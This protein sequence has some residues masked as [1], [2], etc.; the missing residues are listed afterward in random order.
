MRQQQS[1]NQIEDL[2][3]RFYAKVQLASS[4]RRTDANIIAEDVLVP[5]FKEL[6]GYHNLHNV[7]HVEK[8][9][10]AID[11]ADDISRVAIQITA[12]NTAE[13]VTDTLEKFVKYHLYEKY[14][15]L[16]IYILKNKTKSKKNYED[17]TEN[18]FN[19]DPISNIL[20]YKDL[21]QEAFKFDLEKIEN[22]RRILDTHFGDDADS[23]DT[24]VDLVSTVTQAQ[25]REPSIDGI[26]HPIS[27]EIVGVIEDKIENG[28]SVLITGDAGSGKTGVAY[29][30]CSP[31]RKSIEKV[32]Y[33]DARRYSNVTDFLSLDRE[34]GLN[35]SLINAIERLG[36]L[37][38][39]RLIIDQ[40]DSVSAD[41][42]G[43]V[44]ANL[45]QKCLRLHGVKVVVLSRRSEASEI[46]LT[47]I[48]I[49]AG[50]QE[51]ICEDLP[52]PVIVD[53]FKSIGLSEWSP[54]IL[55]LS[56]NLLNLSLVSQIKLTNPDFDFN[57]ILDENELW[58][59][60][61]N[62]IR[63]S[64]TSQANQGVAFGDYVIAEAMRIARE[65]MKSNDRTIILTSPSTVTQRRLE[66]WRIIIHN[67]GYSY[68]F[69]H[70]K[71]HDFLFAHDATKRLLTPNAVLTEIGAH[72]AHN[73]LPWIE[74]LYHQSNK[75]RWISFLEHIFDV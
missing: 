24:L 21:V 60:Y 16:I 59:K 37:F 8:N 41:R 5:L 39:C 43:G 57:L 71:L 40:L 53:I 26:D 6:Y 29:A 56:K 27:R 3:A 23:I 63:A 42:A 28:N 11:L 66:S 68:R 17:I 67:E 9:K 10:Y 62:A 55:F 15:H 13:K 2:M 52:D 75:K 33:F 22:V 49:N 35:N 36:R 51:I 70:D 19:F 4:A 65:A 61:I 30:L 1:Q 72:R 12:T 74:K 73:I 38:G 46:K 18:Y 54:Q 32:I 31:C 50:I 44:F 58:D 20:D 64:E 47:D 7:N 25:I 48:L 34:I 14:D 69:R 45:A